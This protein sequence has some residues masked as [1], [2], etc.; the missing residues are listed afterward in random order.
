[1]KISLLILCLISIFISS[2][3]LSP[4]ALPSN[5]AIPAKIETSTAIVTFSPVPAEKIFPTQLPTISST[6]TLPAID[7]PGFIV[8]LGEQTSSLLGSSLVYSPDGLIIVQAD[9][10]V[11]LWGISTH[12][13]IR[14][15]KYPDSENPNATYHASKALFSPDGSLIAVSI[16]DY[17]THLGSPN[18][19]LL[20]WDVATGELKQD[21]LQENANMAAHDGF[22]SKPNI[23]TI[24]VNAMT[25]LPSSTKLAYANGNRIEIKD[26]R[27]GEEFT[28]WSLGDTMYA[29][30]LSIR[31]D[32]EFLYVLM[33]WYK[34]LTFP[35]LYRYKFKAQIWHPATKS[36]RREIKFEEVYPGIADVWLVGRYLLHQDT[37]NA[38]LEALDLSKD[39]K[40]DF[41]YRI[42]LKYFN[43]DASLMLCL[44]YINRDAMDIEIWNTDTWRNIYAFKTTFSYN[45]NSVAFSPD[46]SLLAIDYHG[47]VYLLQIRP[48]I[49]PQ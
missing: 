13:M 24:P 33:R 29:S 15:L 32:S 42:G 23:Y 6:V 28:S 22:Q 10:S 47:Q 26:A 14:E 9:T 18:G 5:T 35:A 16:T 11:K 8:L 20:V 38:E 19:H 46:N 41:P 34:D 17:L 27:S 36:L 21:W 25:F 44:R 37:N 30:E 1:V 49:Q 45:V 31:G 12:Q 3:S 2:C 43:T 48:A 40:R 7:D 4:A 39:E